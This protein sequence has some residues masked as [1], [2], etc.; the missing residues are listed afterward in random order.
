MKKISFIILL[1]FLLNNIPPALA[2]ISVIGSDY[3]IAPVYYAKQNYNGKKTIDV[4]LIEDLHANLS[5]QKSITEII[6]SVDKNNN[7]KEILIEGASETI[8]P[9]I[10]SGKIQNKNKFLDLL[11]E[12][13]RINGVEYY[14]LKNNKEYKLSGL[15]NKA[16]YNENINK[17]KLIIDSQ[18]EVNKILSDM[19]KDLSRIQRSLYSVK[20][21]ENLKMLQKHESSDISTLKYFAFLINKIKHIKADKP[22]Y[23]EEDITALNGYIDTQK[24]ISSINYKKLNEEINSFLIA[25]KKDF[26]YK[27][28][29]E[30]TDTFNKYDDKLIFCSVI[31]NIINENNLQ[32]YKEIKKVSDIYSMKSA[33]DYKTL[34]KAQKRIEKFIFLSYALGQ[35][36]KQL[37]VLSDM[38]DKYKNYYGGFITE[39]EYEFTKGFG[40]D[41]FEENWRKIVNKQSIFVDDKLAYL[42]KSYYDNNISR[43]DVFMKNIRKA[44]NRVSGDGAIAVLCGGF[45]SNALEILFKENGIS[46]SIITP[47]VKQHSAE[48]RKI[49]EELISESGGVSR[50]SIPP[51][52]FIDK[53]NSLQAVDIL[54]VVYT[55]ELNEQKALE[56]VKN[57]AK[58]L[59][60][61]NSEPFADSFKTPYISFENADGQS[62]VFNIS[63]KKAVNFAD[64]NLNKTNRIVAEKLR[65]KRIKKI[66]ENLKVNPYFQHEYYQNSLSS[67]IDNINSNKPVGH[68]AYDMF[69]MI[70]FMVQSSTYISPTKFDSV[71]GPYQN[72]RSSYER[73]YI[74]Y[75]MEEAFIGTKLDYLLIGGNSNFHY[76]N[77][78]LFKNK[79]GMYASLL[80]KSDTTGS[81]IKVFSDASYDIF[82]KVYGIDAAEDYNN[83]DIIIKSAS[84]SQMDIAAE[85]ELYRDSAAQVIFIN[86]T[87]GN[88]GTFGNK[89]KEFLSSYDKQVFIVLG[90]DNINDIF[91]NIN[92]LLPDAPCIVVSNKL[93]VKSSKGF[94]IDQ[95]YGFKIS[96]FVKNA[97]TMLFNMFDNII[98]DAAFKITDLKP[99]KA[100]I[101]GDIIQNINNL[102]RSFED[103]VNNIDDKNKLIKEMLNNDILPYLR[104]MLVKMHKETLSTTEFLSFQEDYRILANFKNIIIADLFFDDVDY[105]T[106][107]KNTERQYLDLG[108]LDTAGLDAKALIFPSATSASNTFLMYI[109]GLQKTVNIYVPQKAYYEFSVISKFNNVVNKNGFEKTITIFS[110]RP[111]LLNHGA[112]N[113]VF[114]EPI[115]NRPDMGMEDIRGFFRENI[116]NKRF[117]EDVYIFVDNTLSPFMSIEDFTE[118]AKL[119]ENVRVV[120]YCSLHKLHQS[121]LDL[122]SSG[123]VI[124]LSENADKNLRFYND[125]SFLRKNLGY[126]PDKYAITAVKSVLSDSNMPALIKTKLSNTAKLVTGITNI[127]ENFG[128]HSGEIISSPANIRHPNYQMF[129]NETLLNPLFGAPFFFIKGNKYH[130][131]SM[132]NDLK[133]LLKSA[134]V[135][136]FI[137]NS[138]GFNDLS[139][140]RYEDSVRVSVG[141]HDELTLYCI[142]NA[143]AVYAELLHIAS[144]ERMYNSDYNIIKRLTSLVVNNDVI[145]L[146]IICNIL[147]ENVNN[148]EKALAGYGL[149]EK[150]RAYYR[151]LFAVSYAMLYT[152]DNVSFGGVTNL[153][154]EKIK[155]SKK[156]LFHK[157]LKDILKNNETDTLEMF[158]S[159]IKKF[160]EKSTV[161][162]FVTN[163]IGYVLISFLMFAEVNGNEDIL[164]LISEFLE[165]DSMRFTDAVKKYTAVWV[166]NENTESGNAACELVSLTEPGVQPDITAN[167]VFENKQISDILKAS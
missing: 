158:L 155:D 127:L 71:R 160:K 106:R 21:K 118:G 151:A 92:E 152:Q 159:V 130:A 38:F 102:I 154:L 4:Y 6:E 162:K 88:I 121:G 31:S 12:S 27:V 48:D 120:F 107:L 112:V 16:L 144:A 17:L 47:D 115:E 131:G 140:I 138:F 56:S 52:P 147:V 80:F 94:F 19:G 49:Y 141:L 124:L 54:N 2:E 26:P 61:I 62:I 22:L 63:N 150:E 90:L 156:A 82:S 96:Y 85:L 73:S 165:K 129:A 8:K 76:Y 39:Y 50:A 113:A 81:R 11:F 135:Y 42:Y 29:K 15:E 89:F 7:I 9:S 110:D 10:L 164:N 35:K 43:N 64:L 13:S 161:K 78:S 67:L 98:T 142:Q 5:A 32:G 25:A 166:E 123:G 148:S 119:D 58:E 24:G 79:T 132:E 37:L 75:T 72:A 44:L 20:N 163:E 97:I 108:I 45:H 41:A 1:S 65:L 143:F 114:F 146:D 95:R 93:I 53:E 128:I 99:N 23:I 57:T 34:L 157:I 14:A 84:P 66:I 33:T 122:A 68:M 104:D 40:V 111:G 139:M 101:S 18:E 87:S 136:S 69:K 55:N 70:L 36:E 125:I 100:H 145:N 116:N 83:A 60:Y 105:D 28:Y 117:K 109:A 134:G 103:I 59:G 153:S 91:D 149:S 137:R 3:D 46:Y 74:D 30:L 51:E 133:T 167:T 86:V 77:I 126:M